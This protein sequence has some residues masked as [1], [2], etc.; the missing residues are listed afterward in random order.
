MMGR[1]ATK[2]VRLHKYIANCAYCSRRHAELLIAAGRVQVDGRA[3]REKGTVIRPGVDRVVI[4]GDEI[5]PPPRMTIALNKP[6]GYITSTHD[7]HERLTV[8]DLLP[9]RMRQF[10]VFPV[11]RLDLDTEGLLIL[12]NDGDLAHRLA[13]PRH[14]CEKEYRV[15]IAG[16]LSDAGR[17]RLE[18]GIELDGRKTA[19]ARV[20][21][22]RRGDGKTVF[23]IAVHEGRKRQIR[24]MAQALGHEVLALERIR[25]GGLELG[26]LARGA[27]REL[28]PA[29]IELSLASNRPD[30]PSR[31]GWGRRMPRGTRRPLLP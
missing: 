11:G 30:H 31:A 19:P 4:N 23:R 12:T 5:V 10:G 21:G 26:D 20:G 28:E 3:V 8:M 13:H 15:V 14:A 1:M 18:Q 9:R 22:L 16:R 25:I 29:E 27:W 2:P 7:T 6:A 24:C 17:R